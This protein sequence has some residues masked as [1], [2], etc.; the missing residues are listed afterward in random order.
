M[1]NPCP[2]CGQTN[3]DNAE[4]CS[5]GYRFGE[6]A[7]V[8]YSPFSI[9]GLP[10]DLA[11]MVMAISGT[12]VGI[13][14]LAK[15]FSEFHSKLLFILVM[16][17][18]LF[19]IQDFLRRYCYPHASFWKIFRA[20]SPLDQVPAPL[21]RKLYIAVLGGITG[22]MAMLFAYVILSRTWYAKQVGAPKTTLFYDVL[23]PGEVA[24]LYETNPAK[25]Q[26]K[27]HPPVKVIWWLWPCLGA[28]LFPYTLALCGTLEKNAR[29]A[30]QG[31]AV[32]P[33]I[34]EPDLSWARVALILAVLLFWLPVIGLVTGTLAWWG[35]RRATGWRHRLSQVA[36]AATALLHLALAV[37]IVIAAT[38]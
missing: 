5:C 4:Q 14:A 9:R 31:I 28:L 29:L 18:P 21:G 8:T 30:R 33:P 23:H 36:F 25:D 11:V 13:W 32:G 35:N 10:V 20:I 24:P 15:V 3:S 2:L 37:V 16:V 17:P 22:V 27:A 12:S 34:A 1:S 26:G 6:A 38:N 7:A 19:A